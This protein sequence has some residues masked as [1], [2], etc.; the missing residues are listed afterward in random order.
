LKA[1]TEFTAA[2]NS[3]DIETIVALMAD[4]HT[5]STRMAMK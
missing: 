1:V 3:H 2:I 5:F 4:D